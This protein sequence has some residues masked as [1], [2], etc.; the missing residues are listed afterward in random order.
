MVCFGPS[1]LEA[2]PAAVRLPSPPHRHP[3]PEVSRGCV[4]P[5]T[6]TDCG[7]KAVRHD[8]DRQRDPGRSPDSDGPGLGKTDQYPS[9]ELHSRRARQEPND[10]RGLPVRQCPTTA[11]RIG[12]G[13]LEHG[14]PTAPWRVLARSGPPE[15]PSPASGLWPECKQR[16][17][18]AANAGSHCTQAG[19]EPLV[20]G[21]RRPRPSNHAQ[22]RPAGISPGQHGASDGPSLLRA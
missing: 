8:S 15:A 16:L 17:G 11:A 12:A 21:L 22:A 1:S 10:W 18:C 19:P 20:G 5:G 2:W 4:P 9:Q 3:P 6:V 13:A 14:R 7:P